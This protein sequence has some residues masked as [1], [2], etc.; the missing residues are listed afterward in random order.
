MGALDG[1]RILDFTA[2]A[3]GP[4]ATLLLAYLGAEVIKVESSLYLDTFRREAAE[5]LGSK[6]AGLSWFNPLNA[7]KLGITLN[8]KT[9]AGIEIAKRLTRIS[10]V[11]VDNFRAGVMDK[12]GLGYPALREVKPDIIM[13]SSSSHGATGPESGYSGFA[14]TMGPLSG[15]S[16]LTGYP[17]GPPTIL[18]H[19]MDLR[20]G[21]A[22]AFAILAALIHWRRTGE[23]QFIDLSQRE[24]L[25]CSAAES[26]MDYTMN[27]RVRH[28][29]G[30]RDEKM[31]PHNCYRCQGKDKWISIAVSTDQEWQAL[32]RAVGHPEWARQEE[33]R[34][35]LSRWQ[36]QDNL[37][38]LIEGW[39]ASH[40]HY[41]V[42]EIL[43]RAGVAA[44]PSFS[45]EELFN[46]PHLRERDSFVPTQHPEEG[47]LYVLAPPWKLSRT[48]GLVHSP[49]PLLG[50]HTGYVF[51]ELLG[52]SPEEISW[53]VEQKVVC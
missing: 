52:M 19:S 42:M 51:R 28:R 5:V 46:N 26:I 25:S 45:N 41:E 36:N 43:Q 9:D 38:E 6:R 20:A 31:A 15:L 40:T 49:A 17:G 50:Q 10:D 2:H 35:S 48:P 34:D 47:E 33:F 12:L 27:S 37:D 7:N 30:N 44:M 8:L 22:A 1:V 16:H 53:L 13:V 23:G 11:A 18:R 29:N 4:Q 3:A 39:T 21:T 32:C 14:V 24:T